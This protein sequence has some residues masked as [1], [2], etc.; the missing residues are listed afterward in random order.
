MNMIAQPPKR[1][2][3]RDRHLHGSQML[4][5]RT[6]WNDDGARKCPENV[7]LTVIVR[8]AAWLAE[9]E[10]EVWCLQRHVPT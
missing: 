5:W 9:E 1:R 2:T 3:G 8:Y 6:T 7:G 4:W 10:A